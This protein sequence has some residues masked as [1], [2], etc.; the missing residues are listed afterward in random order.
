MQ[1]TA[2]RKPKP[3]TFN[4]I[5]A[6]ALLSI[7]LTSLTTHAGSDFSNAHKKIARAIENAAIKSPVDAM[8]VRHNTLLIAVKKEKTNAKNY[9]K[10]VCDFLAQNGFSAQ[11]TTV[12]IADQAM[13]RLGNKV[14][15]L[16]ERRCE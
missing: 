5:L 2:Q 11:L 9:A 7:T 4:A 15:Q 10:G 3:Y 1:I 13:L 12:V 6:I 8:W 14:V 16:A